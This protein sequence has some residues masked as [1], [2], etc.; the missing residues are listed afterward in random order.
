[1]INTLKK[2]I[3]TQNTPNNV[4]NYQYIDENNLLRF[5]NDA[6]N[7]TQNIHDKSAYE[8]E[9]FIIKENY[10]EAINM[11]IKKINKLNDISVKRV[12][13]NIS[14]MMNMKILEN[15]IKLIAAIFSMKKI[16]IMINFMNI[17]QN[18]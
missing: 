16:I 17:Y 10:K 13:G 14:R 9:V 18:L 3:Q 1:M 2:I 7:M 5:A 12:R 11:P 4:M 6:L 15:R 8:A